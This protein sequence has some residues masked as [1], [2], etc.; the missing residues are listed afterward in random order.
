M[1]RSLKLILTLVCDSQTFPGTFIYRAHSLP[2]ELKLATALA[3]QMTGTIPRVATAVTIMCR[4]PCMS[5]S[6]VTPSF[7]LQKHWPLDL[8]PLLNPGGSHLKSLI[9]FIIIKV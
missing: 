4:D 9:F 6:Q 5:V 2:T 7:L 3:T 1:T 8:E